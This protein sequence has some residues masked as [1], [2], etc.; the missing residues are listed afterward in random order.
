MVLLVVSVLAGAGLWG[1]LRGG[2]RLRMA[3]LRPH[4]DGVSLVHGALVRRGRV[5]PESLVLGPLVVLHWLPEA[6][7]RIERFCLLRDGFDADS[8]RQLCVWVRW[9][10]REV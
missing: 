6:G 7:G 9:A 3:Q 10:L 2:W 1:L 5:L 4:Q 8:W